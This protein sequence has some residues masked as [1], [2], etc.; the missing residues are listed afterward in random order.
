MNDKNVT[1]TLTAAEADAL[2]AILRG[3]VADQYEGL[4][5][6]ILEESDLDDAAIEA[7]E[8]IAQQLA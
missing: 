4:E 6:G 5:D 8:R 3:F 2:K 1:L 7:A